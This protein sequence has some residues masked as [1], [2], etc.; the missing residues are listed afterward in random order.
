MKYPLSI[1][2]YCGIVSNILVDQYKDDD[3]DAIHCGAKQLMMKASNLKKVGNVVDAPS[4]SLLSI[5]EA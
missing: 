4:G 3:K 2:F 1:V 5:T